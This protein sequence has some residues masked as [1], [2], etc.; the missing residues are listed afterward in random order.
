MKKNTVEEL[1]EFLET[2]REKIVES[3]CLTGYT[4]EKAYIN[5]EDTIELIKENF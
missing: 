1:M 5:I 4:R 3:E 2:I